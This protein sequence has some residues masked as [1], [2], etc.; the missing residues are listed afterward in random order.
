MVCESSNSPVNL[1]VRNNRCSI[2]CELQFDYKISDCVASNKKTHLQYTYNAPQSEVYFNNI[3]YTVQD[4]RIYSPSLHQ[5][6][7]DKVDAELVITHATA[8]SPKLVVCVPI[9]KK[10]TSKII[11]MIFISS[12]LQVHTIKSII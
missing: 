2:Q 7:G 10:N 6:D 11:F 9:I 3:S 12:R 1:N 5:F 4:I 8:G